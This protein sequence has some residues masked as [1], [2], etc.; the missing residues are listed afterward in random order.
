MIFTDREH[1]CKF[2]FFMIFFFILGFGLFTSFLNTVDLDYSENSFFLVSGVHFFITGLGLLII[3]IYYSVTKSKKS[4]RRSNIGETKTTWI[5]VNFFIAS[6]Y[7]IYFA[8]SE[9]ILIT[10]YYILSIIILVSIVG[11]GYWIY[12][13]K[14]RSREN[15]N[16]IIQTINEIIDK[17]NN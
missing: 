10:G 14:Y 12:D 3:L 17:E 16:E 11:I 5:F 2:Y 15:V 7:F 9:G 1:C 8:P 13:K 4:D 6:L